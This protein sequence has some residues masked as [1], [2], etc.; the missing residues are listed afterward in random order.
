MDFIMRQVLIVDDGAAPLLAEL[1][2]QLKT[3]Q[4][5]FAVLSA[6]SAPQ[7]LAILGAKKTDLVLS[8]W[9]PAFVDSFLL[10]ISEAS[11]ALPILVLV[12]ESA[13]SLGNEIKI[14]YRCDVLQLGST[15]EEVTKKIAS[16]LHLPGDD[17]FLTNI[18]PASFLKKIY[19]KKETALLTV[20]AQDGR[21]GLIFV[22]SGEI[23]D[24]SFGALTG[25][26]ALF[27]L[28][29]E[30][31]LRIK[32]L[33]VPN[34]KIKRKITKAVPELL[35]SWEAGEEPFAEEDLSLPIS[36]EP[37]PLSK[38][39]SGVSS[40]H[41]ARAAL[42]EEIP[43]PSLADGKTAS[44]GIP[45]AKK[46]ENIGLKLEEAEPSLPLKEK[47]SGKIDDWIPDLGTAPDEDSSS[48][49]SN[50]HAEES[51]SPSLTDSYGPGDEEEVLSLS[52]EESAQ[53]GKLLQKVQ[54]I[55][56][57]LA[58]GLFMPG[59]AMIAEL[60]KSGMQVQDFGGIANDVLLKAQLATEIIGL[61]V[62]DVIHIDAPQAHVLVRCHNDSDDPEVVA[63]EGTHI[64][65]L[66]IMKKQG[67]LGM[68][69]FVL[70]SVV[71]EIAAVFRERPD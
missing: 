26:K 51:A 35:E 69:K 66:L 12:P 33:N 38:P 7:A 18:V 40:S 32:F 24:A 28:L 13:W 56:G 41:A 5:R 1:Q 58:V 39:K 47:S 61:G 62:C 27:S 16:M 9:G 64:H 21:K 4:D 19:K 65:M 60:N 22:H 44:S 6:G 49:K 50:G 54:Q 20:L 67:N 48:L 14:F 46:S 23:W 17:G 36:A 45:G 57:F 15:A 11:S 52:K 68:G 37:D 31:N 63:K 43:E 59:G 34:R 8:V 55:E 53:I 71:A 42:A 30:E 70:S 10:E 29:S 25:E 2:N 3:Q